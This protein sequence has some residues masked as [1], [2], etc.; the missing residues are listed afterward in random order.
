MDNKVLEKIRKLIAKSKCSASSESEV[1]VCM[2]MAQKL[3]MQ[4][5]LDQTDIDIHISDINKEII[6]SELWKYYK[7]KTANFEWN[8]LDT[9]AKSFNCR[10]FKG[11]DYDFDSSD[12]KKTKKDRLTIIGT[13]D[14][15][16]VVKELYDSCVLNFLSFSELRYKE[17]IEKRKKEVL[18]VFGK[19]GIDEKITIKN[20]EK[21]K[22]IHSK[23]T[24]ISSYLIGCV[25][26]IYTYLECQKDEI[27]KIG[28]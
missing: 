19:I 27:L 28:C 11:E 15:R 3:M 16:I 24:F 18:E 22:L 6:H 1:E 23:K 14:N 13:Y 26:G 10:V 20:L 25:N 12:W 2:K 4:Y 8:L 21:R 17:Y 7:F 5:N 9:I